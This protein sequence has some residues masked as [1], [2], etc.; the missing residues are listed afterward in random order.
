MQKM[1]QICGALLSKATVLM[2]YLVAW[3]IKCLQLYP[4]DRLMAQMLCLPRGEGQIIK[5]GIFM[6]DGVGNMYSDLNI[7]IKFLMLLAVAVQWVQMLSFG[8][9]LLL[10]RHRCLQFM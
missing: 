1:R 2:Q 7:R 4:A 6:A 10:I 3:T 9:M 8:L 5:N